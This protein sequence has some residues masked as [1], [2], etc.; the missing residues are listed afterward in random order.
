MIAKLLWRRTQSPYPDVRLSEPYHVGLVVYEIKQLAEDALGDDPER[1]YPSSDQ[2][3]GILYRAAYLLSYE[4]RSPLVEMAVAT[5]IEA[6]G[7][8]MPRIDRDGKDAFV[9]GRRDGMDDRKRRR[10]LG[11]SA[12]SSQADGEKR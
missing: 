4:Q 3:R 2:L 8:K 6:A 11:S 10:R 5:S 7:R 1:V 9:Q 12:P